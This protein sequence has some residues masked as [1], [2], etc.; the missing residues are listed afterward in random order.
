VQKDTPE[1]DCVSGG[2]FVVTPQ[3]FRSVQV[4]L[5]WPLWHALQS[6]QLQFGVQLVEQDSVSL[7]LP[8][9]DPHPFES[10]QTLVCCWLLEHWPQLLQLQLGW[11]FEFAV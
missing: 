7:G 2:S 8:T 4:L 5:C 1:H 3:L 10:V 6:V 11:Q 9:S